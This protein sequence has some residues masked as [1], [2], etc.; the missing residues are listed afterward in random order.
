MK[1]DYKI[2]IYAT[3]KQDTIPIPIKYSEQ[4]VIYSKSV[5]TNNLAAC[6]KQKFEDLSF[7]QNYQFSLC[8]ATGNIVH[9]PT[10]YI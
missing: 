10:S 6:H 2:A 9:E 7:P 8:K 4:S 1:T 5:S 3:N